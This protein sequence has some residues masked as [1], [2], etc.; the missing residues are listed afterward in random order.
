MTCLS[1]FA[2]LILESSNR[3][4][5]NPTGS[6]QDLKR[7]KE[8]YALAQKHDLILIED[9][10]YYFLQME[11]YHP[12]SETNGA[13]ESSSPPT[14]EELLK[15][16]VPSYL[17]MDVD[18]RVIRLDSF[19]KVVAPGSRCGWLTTSPI[20]CERLMR[21]NE[22]SIQSPSG[23][24]QA[25]LFKLLDEHWGHSRYFDWL[26]HIRKEY[27]TRRNIMLEA[28]EKYIPKEIASWTPPAAGMF[29][30]SS[31]RLSDRC[32]D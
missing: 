25:I 17:S 20:I 6:T 13:S 28:C 16:L 26:I 18:G 30:S 23:F 12:A 1:I 21:Q 4:G 8:I 19:S 9:E 14:H 24:S 10:P 2:V 11:D 29:V 15:S 31:F 5:Q 7:R 32:R 3:T 27:S 22:V